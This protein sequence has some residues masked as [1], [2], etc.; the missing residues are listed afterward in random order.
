[1]GQTQ[2]LTTIADGLMVQNKL[3]SRTSPRQ[4]QCPPVPQNTDHQLLFPDWK[5]NRVRKSINIYIY[6]FTGL[7]S[8][9]EAGVSVTSSYRMY[10]LLDCLNRMLGKKSVF[11]RWRPWTEHFQ[12]GYDGKSPLLGLGRL[13]C[14]IKQDCKLEFEIFWTIRYCHNAEVLWV[15]ARAWLCGC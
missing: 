4:R 5:Y 2:C 12:V 3:S 11:L 14:D 6:V 13:V 1:M 9:S 15:V 10:L 8:R 7:F